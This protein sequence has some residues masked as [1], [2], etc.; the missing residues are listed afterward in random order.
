[1]SVLQHTQA[2][3][4]ETM[5]KLDR[6]D[7]LLDRRFDDVHA[8]LSQINGGLDDTAATVAAAN[9]M[10][11]QQQLAMRQLQRNMSCQYINANKAG[12]QPLRPPCSTDTANSTLLE[13]DANPP[14]ARL[15]PITS[16]WIR[17]DATAAEIRV[18]LDFYHV[19]HEGMTDEQLRA[20]L[21][22]IM[23]CN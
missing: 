17:S 5:L 22:D 10:L 13:A 19:H 18:W 1:M 6:Y 9:A 21:V 16:N 7:Q 8:L 14:L 15:L 20:S 3:Q 12:D 2:W 4:A 23:G 11:D